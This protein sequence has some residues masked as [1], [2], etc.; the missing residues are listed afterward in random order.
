MIVVDAKV[1]LNSEARHYKQW[2]SD[3][4]LIRPSFYWLIHFYKISTEVNARITFEIIG[5]KF[6]E[7]SISD[8]LFMP[9][10]E[11]GINVNFQKLIFLILCCLANER[12]FWFA[13]AYHWCF[14]ELSRLSLYRL[15]VKMPKTWIII[16]N[17]VLKLV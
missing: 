3:E 14:S 6:N 15:K 2:I 8:A 5:N 7:S 10:E 17:V 4:I 1:G 16:Y 13:N 12:L 9:A 11:V